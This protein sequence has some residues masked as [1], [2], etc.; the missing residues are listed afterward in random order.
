MHKETLE[1]NSR[2]VDQ[3]EKLQRLLSEAQE[4]IQILRRNTGGFRHGAHENSSPSPLSSVSTGVKLTS[5][6]IQSDGSVPKVCP[7]G[8]CAQYEMVHQRG[9]DAMKNFQNHMNNTHR[10]I[11]PIVSFL[12]LKLQCLS[13]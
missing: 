3:N 2:L 8:G 6:F 9:S 7:L 13:S 11:P 5:A 1:E 12:C 10:V 4:E